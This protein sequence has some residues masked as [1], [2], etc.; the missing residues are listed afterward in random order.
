M[1]A[2]G[3]GDLSARVKVEGK[4]EVARLAETFNAA[5]DRIQNLVTANRALL[6]NAS[7]ELRSPL[8]RLRMGVERLPPDSRGPVTGG[9]DAQYSRTGR[10]DR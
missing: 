9:T 4:D 2:L 5:A 3:Q 8:A 1:A 10:A 7:H 6:A